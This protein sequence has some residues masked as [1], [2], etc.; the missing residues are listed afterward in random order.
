MTILEA[1]KAKVNYPLADNNAEVSLLTRGIADTSEDFTGE[2]GVSKAFELAYADMLKFVCTMVNLSQGGSVTLPSNHDNMKAI[3][4][5]IY[6]KYGLSDEVV[7][8]GLGVLRDI[9]DRW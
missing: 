7:D 3:A 2:I 1:L 5:R 9:S 4:N 6:I 8:G